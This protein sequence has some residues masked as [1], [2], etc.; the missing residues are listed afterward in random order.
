MVPE[1]ATTPFHTK[2]SQTL[3]QRGL[4]PKLRICQFKHPHPVAAIPI[5][6]RAPT[7]NT[8]PVILDVAEAADFSIANLDKHILIYLSRIQRY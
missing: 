7:Q 1:I 2:V 6:D 4:Q 3:S 8:S 5:V